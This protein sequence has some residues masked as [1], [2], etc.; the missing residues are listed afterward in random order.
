M[1]FIVNFCRVERIF[2][3]IKASL[4]ERNIHHDF[5]LNKLSLVITRVTA[6]LGILVFALPLLIMCLSEMPLFTGS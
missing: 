3:D 4:K 5:Q 1:T 6:F 2:D